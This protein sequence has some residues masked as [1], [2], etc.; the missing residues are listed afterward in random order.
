MA[1]IAFFIANVLLVLVLVGTIVFQYIHFSAQ[2]R[3]K[4][5]V[6]LTM[7]EQGREADPA[8]ISQLMEDG[9]KDKAE[10]KNEPELIDPNDMNEEER[11]ELMEADMR[12][13]N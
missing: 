4:D 5:V 6:I 12:A 9:L 8:V 3:F 10:E 11:A 1:L 13:D 2:L 7:R